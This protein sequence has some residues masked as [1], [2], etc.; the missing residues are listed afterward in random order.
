VIDDEVSLSI[1]DELSDDPSLLDEEAAIVNETFIK[2]PSPHIMLQENA[3][4]PVYS[5]EKDSDIVYIPGPANSFE[6]IK[7]EG[8]AE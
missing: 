1:L 6:P 7:G 8:D 2:L 5:K 4:L 3:S